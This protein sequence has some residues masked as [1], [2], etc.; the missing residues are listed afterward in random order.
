MTSSVTSWL[1]LLSALGLVLL[2]WL[3]LRAALVIGGQA[4]AVKSA[5][6][7]DHAYE[8]WARFGPLRLKTGRS[9]EG[10]RGRLTVSLFGWSIVDRPLAEGEP[11]PKKEGALSRRPSRLAQHM[12]VDWLELCAWALERR[13]LVALDPV[14]GFLRYGLGDPARTG[15]VC[16][17][18]CSLTGMLPSGW[19]LTHEAVFDRDV[20]EAEASGAIRIYAVPML[21]WIAWFV[22]SR[23]KFHARPRQP[24]PAAEEK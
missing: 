12:E 5:A 8:G 3:L 7:I 14:Q 4:A 19:S 1:I 9:W 20:L 21:S 13:Y 18:L 6:G 15:E 24:L 2:G 11:E 10:E 16:G 22:L 23:V 17:L